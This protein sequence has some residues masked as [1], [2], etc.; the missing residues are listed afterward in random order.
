MNDKER[1]MKE[2]E[3][4]MMERLEPATTRATF[5]YMWGELDRNGFIYEAK[6]N[7]KIFLETG[8]P[9][10]THTFV[11]WGLVC[12]FWRPEADLIQVWEEEARPYYEA[13]L[14]AEKLPSPW[15]EETEKELP[16][17]KDE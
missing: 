14:L 4:R 10:T 9:A 11:C 12:R 6:I 2:K 7:A 3:R 1:R 13:Q 8:Q 15:H 16:Y 17:Q 5:L